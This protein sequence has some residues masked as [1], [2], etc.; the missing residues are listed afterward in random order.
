MPAKAIVSGEAFPCIHR[1]R[2]HGP[3]LQ[4]R[5]C[6]TGPGIGPR[7]LCRSGPCPR[8]RSF[9]VKRFLASTA[10]AA[11]GRSYT[12]GGASPVPVSGHAFFVGAGHARESDHFG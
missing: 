12:G 6:I 7:F 9:R 11:T 5:G 2:G 8:K 3:L 4:G 10:F 1:F